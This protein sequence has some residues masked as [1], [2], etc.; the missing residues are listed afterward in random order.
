MVRL[1]PKTQRKKA[2][3]SLSALYRRVRVSRQGKERVS[4]G[5]AH[6]K[7]DVGTLSRIAVAAEVSVRENPAHE[8]P[9]LPSHEAH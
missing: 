6:R 9:I 7:N 8:K 3:A 4:T 2:F 1:T 5:Q